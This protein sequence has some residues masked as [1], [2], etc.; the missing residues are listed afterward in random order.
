M[1]TR[2]AAADKVSTITS[3]PA[4][5]N[6]AA[7]ERSIVVLPAPAGPTTVAT[8]PPPP[9]ISSTARDLVVAELVVA[10]GSHL[11]GC[12]FGGGG[13]EDTVFGV[14]DRLGRV[15]RGADVGVFVVVV[16]LEGDGIGR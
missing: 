2:A 3:R 7:T 16:D 15:P 4:C 12:W 1:T 10:D 5:S 11:E 8:R 6:D 9:T 13:G 14:E